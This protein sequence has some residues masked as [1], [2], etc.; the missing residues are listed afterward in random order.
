MIIDKNKL[1]DIK[2]NYDSLEIVELLNN[3][4]M[5]DYKIFGSILDAVENI[6]N[7]IILINYDKDNKSFLTFDK[8]TNPILVKLI[9]DDEDINNRKM[10]INK[11]N[12]IHE[13]TFN[14]DHDSLYIDEIKKNNCKTKIK[15]IEKN[16]QTK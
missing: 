13:Y 6:G 8:H 5:D 4:C 15:T 3:W 2:I 11:Y 12:T 10:I 9:I 16:K 1:K 14:N 7:R